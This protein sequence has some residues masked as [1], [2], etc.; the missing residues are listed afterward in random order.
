MMS[1]IKTYTG[2][3]EKLEPN[4]IFVFGSNTEGR[5][6]KGAAK[7]ARDKFGAIYGQAE[8]L[9]GQSYAI[10]TK[11]LKILKPIT[12]TWDEI[13]WQIQ[14]FYGFATGTPELEFLVAYKAN[15]INL[16]GYT[17]AQMSSMFKT[18]SIPDNVVFEKDFIELE[19]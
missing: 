3:I 7:I 4:Q 19:Y 6:G 16:N 9:Q 15:S 18:F 14:K 11:D 13:K 2:I 10:I 17:P 5:H 1:D 12:R 8:G